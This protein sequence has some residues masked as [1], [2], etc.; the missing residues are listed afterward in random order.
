MRPV[1]K[2]AFA[3]ERNLSRARIYQLI[4]D[5]RIPVIVGGEHDGKIDA[6]DAHARLGELLDQ[7]KGIRR[8]GNITSSAPAAANQAPSGPDPELPLSEPGRD[9]DRTGSTLSKNDTSYWEHKAKQQEYDALLTQ[10]RYLKEAGSLTSAAGVRKEALE[11]ARTL[12]NA[13]LA[14]PD[15]I[16]SVLDPANPARAHKL[17]TEEIRKALREFSDRMAERAAAAGSEQSEPA[18]V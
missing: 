2:A 10:A 14:I 9:P 6:D 18:L 12:R 7:T 3:K 5:G 8:D 13:M 11:T 16:A 1:T 15:R 4:G 17:L